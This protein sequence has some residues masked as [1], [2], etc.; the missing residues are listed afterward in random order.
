MGWPCWV[1]VVAED[2]DAQ[3]R[4]YHDVLGLTELAAGPGWVQFDLGER[5]VLE[6]VQ[7][8]GERQYD[9]ARY[10]VGYAVADI[11]SARDS[12]VSRGVQSV[13][14]DRRGRSGRRTLVLLP[15]RRGQHLRHQGT[16]RAASALRPGRKAAA[17]A[18]AAPRTETLGGIRCWNWS[19]PAAR[20]STTTVISTG[21]ASVSPTR[22]V[23]GST[24]CR[25]GKWHGLV[26]RV[27][28]QFG[29]ATT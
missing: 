28:M 3:R 13:T 22:C 20:L 14:R 19:R 12:L 26:C 10:Q 2:L 24:G 18:P 16:P 6:L 11:E 8:S 29:T 17:P 5:G 1:G 7:R 9:D 27:T 15:R 4:F 23:T 21:G 25:G